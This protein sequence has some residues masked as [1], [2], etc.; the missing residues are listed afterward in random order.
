MLYLKLSESK[1]SKIFSIGFDWSEILIESGR[2][3]KENNKKVKNFIGSDKNYGVKDIN[4]MET[5]C[6]VAPFPIKINK[7]VVPKIYSLASVI[8]KEKIN[9]IFCCSFTVEDIKDDLPAFLM[10][11]VTLGEYDID[12]SSGQTLYWGCAFQDGIVVSNGEFGGSQ[13]TVKDKIRDIAPLLNEFS[14]FATED[15]LEFLEEFSN[16]LPISTVKKED[17]EDYNLDNSSIKQLKGVSNLHLGIAII[18]TIF[19]LNLLYT[20]Y[21]NYQKEQ[22]IKKIQRINL[23]S[24]MQEKKKLTEKQ[25]KD[26]LLS[27]RNLIQELISSGTTDFT[28]MKA[29]SLSKIMFRKVNAPAFNGW[30]FT[31]GVCRVDID[32][33][34]FYY[35]KTDKTASIIKFA[36]KRHIRLSDININKKGDTLSYVVKVPTSGNKTANIKKV[37][38][39]NENFLK[40][41]TAKL[42]L[43]TPPVLK[44]IEQ[45]DKLNNLLTTDSSLDWDFKSKDIYKNNNKQYHYL[46][47][48][49]KKYSFIVKSKD[50]FILGKVN[51]IFKDARWPFFIKAFKFTK[52]SSNKIS[53]VVKYTYIGR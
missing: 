18:G 30:D 22:K 6:S 8:A 45:I 26:K 4:E 40:E 27:R 12:F 14:L 19:I 32:K 21:E 39:Q 17:I 3:K 2:T 1:K 16:G 51:K 28:Q 9:G 48:T 52:L 50:P 11:T 37:N 49:F 47:D 29:S 7:F 31:E 38:Y 53:W 43:N 42:K 34:A 25:I 20:Q 10:K 23:L 46:P 36:Q 41:F 13:E 15:V 35:K 5:V 24:K 44:K 33:C